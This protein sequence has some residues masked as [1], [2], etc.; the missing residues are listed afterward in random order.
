VNAPALGL[1]R[2][3]SVYGAGLPAV[4][5]LLPRIASAPF[6]ASLRSLRLSYRSETVLPPVD[7]GLLEPMKLEA[8]EVSGA[9][10]KFGPALTRLRRL[11]WTSSLDDAAL[12][13]RR[14]V[15]PVLTT[16]AVDL[17]ARPSERVPWADFSDFVALL[18]AAAPRLDTFHLLG[19]DAGAAGAFCAA[20]AK[21]ELLARLQQLDLGGSELPAGAERTRWS[22][23]LGLPSAFDRLTLSVP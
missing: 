9:G 19:L 2:A 12:L 21:N 18:A 11:E 7:A 20:L 6:A 13:L 14:N 5:D 16:V 10:L 4:R 15:F 22:A 8:L 1:T 23:S 17:P 3:L